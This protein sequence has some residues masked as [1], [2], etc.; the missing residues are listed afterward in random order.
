MS[1]PRPLTRNRVFAAIQHV[2]PSNLHSVEIVPEP[3]NM[4]H[5]HQVPQFATQTSV[6]VNNIFSS[7][8]ASLSPNNQ[9]QPPPPN[10]PPQ[11]TARNHHIP[12]PPRRNSQEQQ[13]NEM[14]STILTLLQQQAA[15][16]SYVE[17][18]QQAIPQMVNN[19]VQNILHNA[20]QDEASSQLHHAD[21]IFLI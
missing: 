21:A 12:N 16:L 3:V 20:L 14:F 9:H 11:N 8:H 19:H 2:E 7:I 6:P 17:Q 18:I 1:R 13:T 5:N 10:P 15:R 4:Q